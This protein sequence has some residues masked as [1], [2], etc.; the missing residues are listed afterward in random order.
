MTFTLK[1][2]FCLAGIISFL[3]C[4]SALAYRPFISTDAA[5]ADAGKSEIELGADYINDHGQNTVAFPS[6]RY[7]Y[8][9][10]TNWEATLEGSLQI[11]D[12][13][14]HNDFQL[15]ASQLD[16]KG[17]LLEGPLQ[18]APR[19]F[20]LG[21]ELSALLPETHERSGSGFE[22]VLLGGF[23]TGKFTWHV[24]AG[25]GLERRTLQ[26]LGIWGIIVEHPL[27]ESLRLAL[28]V[29]GEAERGVSANNSTLLGILWNHRGI[30]YDA[31]IRFGLNRVAPNCAF[32][33]GLT[34]NF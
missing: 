30:T 28:E 16:V 12:S 17:V 6:V 8:G 34:F 14:S 32:T 25:G 11:F 26:P 15:L 33:T 13:A 2:T 27:T 10:V 29:N 24:N 19:P 5:V 21:L 18:D 22:G 1:S 9:L 20:S 23:R 3:F 31:G 4:R 7:N